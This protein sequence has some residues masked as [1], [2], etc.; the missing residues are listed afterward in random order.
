MTDDTSEFAV[1]DV[2]SAPSAEW[3]EPTD[4]DALSRQAFVRAGAAR[5]DYTTWLP[6]PAAAH[7]AEPTEQ[8]AGVQEPPIR[9][10]H[11]ASRPRRGA[12]VGLLSMI[13]VA[14]TVSAVVWVWPAQPSPPTA[15]APSTGSPAPATALPPTS[16][17]VPVAWCESR[18][19][20]ERVSGNSAGSAASGPEVILAL[21][22]AYY[23]RRDATAVRT[24][25]APDGRFGSDAEIQAGIDAIPTGTTH[26][27]DIIPAGPDRWAVTV[28][29][30]W[31]NDSRVVHRQFISTTSRDNRTLVVAVE[32]A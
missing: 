30:R 16:S 17:T 1:P 15:S 13:G 4:L 29:E 23:T 21:E 19:G 11:I 32:P 26:C 9:Q 10:R 2:Y 22:Y 12:V 6:H 25:L 14:A 28:T 5:P 3:P 20:P 31:P 27:V 7:P 24:L 18:F 8:P